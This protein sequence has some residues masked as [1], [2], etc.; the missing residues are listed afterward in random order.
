[1]DY[2][3][4]NVNSVDSSTKT[5]ADKVDLLNGLK[6]SFNDIISELSAI[7]QQNAASSEETTASMQ[8]LNATFALI[9]EAADELRDLAVNLNEKMNYFNIEGTVA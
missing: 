9:T 1:M 4:K 6:V 5:I 7:S 8:E 2:V 3:V